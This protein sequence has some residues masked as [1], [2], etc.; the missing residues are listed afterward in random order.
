MPDPTKPAAPDVLGPVRERRESL[1]AAMLALEAALSEPAP[2][3]EPAWA[4]GVQRALSDLDRVVDAHVRAT[5]APG[6]LF[7]QVIE[8]SP[9]LSRQV[10]RLRQD[11]ADIAVARGAVPGPPASGSDAP[12]V[13]D[14]REA[15]LQLL[16]QLARHRH[17]G[18]DLLHEA[19]SV[20]ISPGN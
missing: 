20:D 14:V 1:R 11:H 18:A 10:A 16:G 4:D 5:E 17:R 6:G 15:A 19:Y 2:G 13:E 8:E 7:E 12:K 9:R 3:R